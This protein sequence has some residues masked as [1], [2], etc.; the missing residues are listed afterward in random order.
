MIFV[1]LSRPN[2]NNTKKTHNQ[3]GGKFSSIDFQVNILTVT[4]ITVGNLALSLWSISVDLFSIFFQ[5]IFKFLT[6]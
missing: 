1:L 4:Q 2:I 5:L 6:F 3:H